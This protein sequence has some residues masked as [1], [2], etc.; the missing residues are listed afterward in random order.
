M[1]RYGPPNLKNIKQQFVCVISFAYV[2][3]MGTLW[4]LIQSSVEP[5]NLLGGK[6]SVISAAISV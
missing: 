2:H 4:L 5:Y 3:A 1:H 6:L